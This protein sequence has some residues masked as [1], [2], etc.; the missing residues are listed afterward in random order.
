MRQFW[1]AMIVM[2]FAGGVWAQ[3][4]DQSG[5]SPD[6]RMERAGTAAV[7]D[8]DA[9]SNASAEQPAAQMPLDVNLSGADLN[10]T[11]VGDRLVITGVKSDVDQV[12]NFIDLISRDVP[13]KETRVVHLKNRNAQAIAQVI[14]KAAREMAPSDQPEQAVTV[15]TV[16]SNILLM[17]GPSAR[18]DELGG[19]VEQL[20]QVDDV[21]PKVQTMTYPLKHIKAAQAKTK[22]EE[23][24]NAIR[25]KQGEDPANQITVMALDAS[26]SLYVIA[27][28]TEH[29]KIAKLIEEIDIE[30]V[31]GYGDLK[32]AY[33]PLIN[34][35]ADKMA[36]VLNDLFQTAQGQE[37]LAE[38]IRRIR[39]VK[40]VPGPNGEF[41]ELPPINL[42][43]QIKLI[44]DEDSQALICATAEENIG[45]LSELIA[46]LDT[47]PMAVEQSMRIFALKHADADAV[48]DLIT[49]MFTQG[50][51]LPKPAP[52]NEST[53]AVPQNPVGESLVYNLG[54]SSDPRTN[55]LIVTGRPEQLVLVEGVIERVDVPAMELKHPLALITLTQLDATRVSDIIQKLWDQRIEAMGSTKTGEAAIAREKIFLSV[56]LR[57]NSLIVA[58]TD[59][60]VTEV[61]RIVETLD[62]AP[63]RYNDQIRL[64]NCTMTSA[65]DLKTKIDELWKRK[66]DLRGEAE[67]PQDLPVVVADQ[68]SNSLIIASSPEDYAEI[69]RLVK[70]LE[71][72]PLAP[73]AEIRLLT[74]E[75]NDAAQIG[76][77][78]KQL[79]EERLQQR[80]VDGQQENPSDRVAVA[81]EPATN[82]LLIAS[83]PDNYKEI[84]R[85]VAQLDVE[86]NLEGVVR[87]FPLANA[88]AQNVADR[89]KELFDQGLY[90]GSVIGD[91][92]IN[93]ARQKVSLVADARSNAVIVSAS[94]TNLSIVEKLIEQ[95]DTDRAPLVNA[96]TRMYQLT[97]GDS[98]KIADMLDRLFQGMAGSSEEFDAPTI[99]ADAVSNTLI[100]TGSRD[101]IKRATDLIM[102]L[103]VPPTQQ[104][105]VQVYKLQHASAAKLA[106]KITQ[107]FDNREQGTE[108][109]RTP[110]YIMP[111]EPTNS[112]IASASAEDQATIRHLLDL[113]DVPSSISRRVQVFPLSQAKAEA[114]AD[115][116]TQ[117]FDSQAQL[118]GGESK[119]EGIVVQPDKRTNALVVWA[120]ESE[121]TNIAQIVKKLDTTTPGP[122]MKVK[123]I[124]L[125]RALAQNLADA[126]TQTFAG[127]KGGGGSEDQSVILSYEEQLPD[128]STVTRK[129]LKQDITIVPDERT[130]SLFVMAP[131]GSMEMLQGLIVSIDRIPPTVAE[132]R[133]F[134]LANA[135]AEEVVTRLTELLESKQTQGP[136][137]QLEIGGAGLG[138]AP[139]G[140]AGAAGAA[141]AAG[142]GEGTAPGQELRFTADRRTNTVI[143][144]GAEADLDMVERVI[145]WL[146][147]QDQDERMRF[148]YEARYIPATDAATAM[149][150]FL[151]EENQLLGDLNDQ[152][153][154]MRQAERHVT[155][156]GDEESNSL[157]VGVSPRNY[158]R[159]ME[160]L[161]SIDRPPP[162]VSIQ[163]LIAEVILDDSLEFGMEWAL[164]DLTFS[165][166][167]TVGPNGIV[168]GHDFDFVGGTDVGAAGA[169]G[170]FG[171]FSFAITGEDFG[172]LVRALQ[173]DGSLEVLS[174]P[175]IT[176]ANN[177]EANI[178]IGDKVPFLRGST[179]TDSGQTQSQVEY[180]DVGIKLLVTPHINPDG[181]VNLEVNP[182]I[183]ALNSGSNV[184]ISEGLTAPT[185]TKRSAETVVTVKDGE[186][187]VIGGLIQTTEDERETKVP[188]VGDLPYVG[189]L[190]RAQTSTRRRT[191]LLMVLTVN[192]LRDEHD[193]YVES[194]KL[195]DQSGFMPDK[196]R[197][198]PL[199]GGLRVLPDDQTDLDQTTPQR[200]PRSVRP[201]DRP[202]YGPAP[203]IY[204]PDQPGSDRPTS[205]GP[206]RE[207][208][209]PPTPRPAEP[210]AMKG[211]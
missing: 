107:V 113:L 16:A 124:T 201:G 149:K 38:T 94:K 138:A 28:E 81:A 2:V 11:V 64:I 98:V 130:N 27:P 190:F 102:S 91:N 167:A 108:S 148:V 136:E 176:V 52:G 122:E 110:A 143:A 178:T 34:S 159:T 152:S 189:N 118:G 95:M 70:T 30:P 83:S 115:V 96:D 106:A 174:R 146:D 128:G 157:L 41:E 123:V 46:L 140:P 145:R 180:E 114:T 13:E 164:Q 19:I 177:Q 185:F 25:Q 24:I 117:L 84:E 73:M 62:A 33:F 21:L 104:A 66:A 161:Y 162:Q 7:N 195:R 100:I 82:T 79:F 137:A 169:A 194:T 192:V 23:L 9:N 147:A 198:N 209:G 53:A 78:I 166:S 182:E 109:K 40:N 200:S 45:P 35:K 184:Q 39:M 160:M 133:M 69:E 105:A 65:A 125:R 141:G 210:V 51:D 58:G 163:V 112:L 74:L 211:S 99:V 61:K 50:K 93:E 202:L 8:A 88:Q 5:A 204:G 20:D 85:I 207:T 59:E 68:R 129:L 57:S 48:K 199:M 55:V 171:G 18:L 186:T 196:I 158:S 139:A 1:T 175:Q 76:D 37:E 72:Q 97:A 134:P 17:T 67:Q 132:I 121:M 165:K 22:L 153:S 87:V 172:F 173:S 208:Y 26:N 170:S 206:A 36:D 197:R 168:T 15:A 181:Y 14:E 183:S 44:P 193:A 43:R 111:D 31:E 3:A 10:V 187:I 12:E 86:P 150:E 77:M 80:Q 151:D 92:Q 191:E 29:E 56:D 155:V 203:Q 6:S 54:V 42:E 179:I 205:D 32:L 75:N 60:N 188:I 90:T 103:D 131:A 4:E 63:D 156:V 49:D 120:A 116:L 119:S 127:G 135:D 71:G 101:A 126:L 154:I 144:A 142:S 89:V 47:V